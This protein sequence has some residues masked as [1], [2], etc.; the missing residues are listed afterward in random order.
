MTKHKVVELA[1]L[2]V[3]NREPQIIA[4]E[5][6]DTHQFRVELLHKA[7]SLFDH[8]HALHPDVILLG[9]G[10]PGADSLKLCKQL[11]KDVATGFLPVIM[12][13]I[14]SGEEAVASF[15]AGADD[16]LLD[17][18]EP[19]EVIARVRVLLRLKRQYDA[20][21]T[22]NRQLAERLVQQ[23]QALAD[24]LQEV[25]NTKQITDNIVYNLS[26]ELRTPL[27]QVKSAVSMLRTDGRDGGPEFMDNLIVHAVAATARL[28]GVIQNLT[29]L[30]SAMLG[31]RSTPEPFRVQD[32]V[33]NTLRQRNRQWLSNKDADRIVLKLD[34][35]PMVLGERGGVTQVLQQLIANAIKF[36]PKGGPVEVIAQ[37]HGEDVWIAVRDNGIGIAAEHL[38]NIFKRFY[39]VDGSSIRAFGGAGVG[40][41]IVKLI[42]DRM[43]TRIEVESELGVGSTFGFKLPIAP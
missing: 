5:L 33:N 13:G 16:M 18:P 20:L 27:L 21:L 41:A 29:Q 35:V 39:Q 1:T 22:E 37:Q 42:L 23:N 7:D 28:E 15:N 17:P 32:A 19:G 10:V 14:H 11:K 38:E 25:S 4:N 2:L 30:T 12:T 6:S 26:H 31:K 9:L 43:D 34:D 8:I 36:S 3:V 24:A 40:L